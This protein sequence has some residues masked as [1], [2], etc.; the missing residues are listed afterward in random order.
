MKFKPTSKAGGLVVELTPKEA[1]LPLSPAATVTWPVFR[2]KKI[3]V[4]LDFSPCSQKAF[5]YAVSF[6]RQF[7]AELILLHVLEP[8]PPV[9]QMDP[10]DLESIQNAKMQL[11]VMAKAIEATIP[12]QTLLR[13]GPPH[14][15][16]V[17]AAQNLAVDLIILSTHGHTGLAHALLGSTVDKVARHAS[18]PVLIVREHEHD[19]IEASAGMRSGSEVC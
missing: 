14:S 8:Y 19:F 9:P 16:I 6:A 4:P 3:L 5:S 2:L 12:A 10:L 13:A 11:E 15:E 18:C 7:G 17:E 1:Q